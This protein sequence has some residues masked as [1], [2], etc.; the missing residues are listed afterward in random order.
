MR[1]ALAAAL[2]AGCLPLDAEKPECFPDDPCPG[3]GV[4]V[5]GSCSAATGR[6]VVVQARGCLGDDDAQ[7]AAAWQ[8][9][10]LCLV[11]EDDRRTLSAALPTP[12]AALELGLDAGT[13]RIQA[14][15]Y[16]LDNMVAC[17]P[18]LTASGACAV[19]AGCQ[20]AW[21][22]GPFT[23]EAGSLT[24]DFAAP[25]CDVVWPVA[26]PAERCD[27][28]DQ[29]CD[30]AVDEDFALS[31]ACTVGVGACARPGERRCGDDGQPACMGDAGDPVD[32][33][34]ADGLDNDCDGTVDEVAAECQPGDQVACGVDAGACVAGTRFCGAEGTYGPCVDA[35][36]RVVVLPDERE[37][38][39][40]GED[41]DCDGSVDEAFRLGADGPP[42]GAEC[43]GGLGICAGV[44]RVICGDDAP[45]CELP[46]PV[47]GPERCNALDDDCDGRVDEDLGVGDACAA[48][49]GAC[50]VEGRLVCR[51]EEAV[52]DA[53]AAE[54]G[55][56]SCAAPAD[57]DCDGT[58][59]EGF[60]AVGE[61]C[62][63]GQGSCQRNGTIVCGDDGLAAACNVAPGDPGDETCNL[64]DDDCDGAV[65]EDF[66]T[67]ADPQNCGECGRRC[68][69]DQATAG[70]EAGECTVAACAEGFADDDGV[71]A[72]GCECQPGAE[73]EPDAA[74][75]DVNCDGVDGP[76]D[77][78]V[79]VA[80]PDGDDG[81]AGTLEAPVATVAQ[82]VAL[83]AA[84]GG[85]PVLIVAGRHVLGSTL[86]VPAGVDLHGGYLFDPAGP[87]W[88]RVAPDQAATE[89]AGPPVVLR[90]Q[91]LG[92]PTL[93]DLVR[94][95]AGAAPAGQ[96]SY[97]ILAVDVGD[98]LRLRDVDVE[99]GRGGVG[100]PGQPGDP[101]PEL[102]AIGRS[103]A[104]G[105]DPGCPG[106]GG[107]P[108]TN[109]GCPIGTDGGA[110]GRSTDDLALID[111]RPG[112]GDVPGAA[113]R[114]LPGQA[115]E[116][117]GNGGAGAVG[118]AGLGSRL[119]AASILTGPAG[120]PI[121]A[122]AVAWAPRAAA[123]AVAARARSAAASWAAAVPAA[124]RAAA[125]GRWP[126]RPR[127]RRQLRPGRLRRARGPH[128]RPPRRWPRRRRRAWR[129][130]RHRRPRRQQGPG[131]PRGARLRGLHARRRRRPRRP[132]RRLRWRGWR[133]GR[134]AQR[135]GLQ[136][137][138][139]DARHR[140]RPRGRAPPRSGR[141]PG[142]RA[143]PGPARRRRPR[144]RLGRLPRPRRRGP[145]GP[146]GREPLLRPRPRWLLPPRRL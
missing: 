75:E 76:A 67:D 56:E 42:V 106:C 41:D 115:G 96:S 123:A 8:G 27:G 74:F 95:R 9:A 17:G 119:G 51:D 15:L 33:V 50:R 92:R 57:E 136:P 58:V 89:L 52:C 30:G 88:S 143:Q 77:R 103:G 109:A 55:V 35:G 102:A 108:G 65:D 70:C 146:H 110:G 6:P 129:R 133:G 32:E 66:D 54:P 60:D 134:W 26:P 44:G 100:G 132:R 145:R 128:R 14:A 20:A 107:L 117:G 121:G 82:G 87:A 90:Y 3:G 137:G 40:N 113:G 19:E 62:A 94:V 131:R 84:R 23:A 105:D 93:L 13:T 11:V 71:A 39:C 38:A 99:A 98:H 139:R 124:A 7:C 101:A 116:R 85:A 86:D 5:A 127:R 47:G 24:L 122:R 16:A 78:A 72:N 22:I 97:A 21:R 46:M 141:G 80:G 118:P 73:D 28:G 10:G 81:A 142:P 1:W 114:A 25:A 43:E 138:E 79:F 63:V 29:D 48:G 34:P 4:C 83:A 69:L 112:Q 104:D 18:E 140:P 45:V 61:P 91:Q 144:R 36:G 130:G 53:V 59:D 2:M 126:R 120:C 49:V 64:L 125:R 68:E 135:G 111:G 31:M 37:E 12:D